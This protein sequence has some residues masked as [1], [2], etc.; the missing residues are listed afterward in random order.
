MAFRVD[1]SFKLV[2]DKEVDRALAKLGGPDLNSAAKFALNNLGENI[3]GESK[4][5]VPVDE[6]ILRGTGHVDPARVVNSFLVLVEMG[7]GGPSAPYALIQHENLDFQHKPGEKAKYLEDPFNRWAKVAEVRIAAD[8][9][10]KLLRSAF[11]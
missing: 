11:R 1:T 2:G 7:Y 6:G 5:E 4:L 3:M 8:L 9:R 10:R